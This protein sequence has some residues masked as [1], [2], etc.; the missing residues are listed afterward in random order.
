MPAEAEAS[1]VSSLIPA[2]IMEYLKNPRYILLILVT[3]FA[4]GLGYMMF[5]NP[6]LLA[7]LTGRGGQNDADLDDFEEDDEG[8]ADL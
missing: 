8:G 6:S 2:N 4:F 3:L 7:K 5:S 1:F